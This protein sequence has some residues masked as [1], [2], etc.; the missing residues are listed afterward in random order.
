MARRDQQFLIIISEDDEEDVRH[1]AAELERYDMALRTL[2]NM[3]IG[4]EQPSESTKLTVYRFGEPSDVGRLINARSVLGFYLAYAGD[5]VA[6][7]PARQP[8]RRSMTVVNVDRSRNRQAETDINTVLNHE[9]VHYFMLQRFAATYPRW[10]VE[11]YAELMSTL[12]FNEDGSFHV[13]DPP[14]DRAY[15]IFQMSAFD[16]EEMFDQNHTLRRW[17]ALQHYATGW[18]FSH[19]MFFDPQR[20]AQLNE[21]LVALGQGEDSLTAARRIFGD[22]DALNRALYDYKDGGDGFP[23]IQVTIPNYVEPQVEMRR[24]TEAEEGNIREE[25]ELRMQFLDK[26]EASAIA[27]SILADAGG[28]LPNDGHRLGL[29]ARAYALAE[30]WQQVIAVADHMSEVAPDEITGPLLASQAAAE[31]SREDANWHDRAVQYAVDAL[32]IDEYDPRSRIAFYYAFYAAGMEA[33][34]NAIIALEDAFDTAGSDRGY[35]H[36]LARQLLFENRLS[37][38]K[39]VLMPIA[40]SGHN[41]NPDGDEERDPS[42]RPPSLDE[43]VEQID[44]GD[45]DAALALMDERINWED[46]DDA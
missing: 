25:M 4:E 19:Y 43:I 24:L 31:L 13:G 9:Y 37:D 5:N 28:T 30:D 6:F 42:E 3:P 35:R 23:G 36:L 20:Y 8:R 41:Q 21:Y 16:L 40:F 7:A 18:L 38:A 46:P 39:T 29:L 1:F 22:L 27:R 34:E 2:Q 33:P 17:D 32:F 12:R 26:D 44:A 11:G 15:Q 14:Q 10:Y 45:R